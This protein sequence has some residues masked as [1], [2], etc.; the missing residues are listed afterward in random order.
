MAYVLTWDENGVQYNFKGKSRDECRQI[1]RNKVGDGYIVDRQN[2]GEI[3]ANKKEIK[4]SLSY[5]M[6]SAEQASISL[7][8]KV[9]KSGIEI[10]EHPSH[11]GRNYSTITIAAPVIIDNQRVYMAVVVKKQVATDIRRIE[12]LIPMV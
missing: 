8:Q 5:L 6:T 3:E 2:F 1:I 4:N 9:L 12:C 11:K 10:A 7:V